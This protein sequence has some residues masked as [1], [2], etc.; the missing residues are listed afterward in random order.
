MMWMRLWELC[1]SVATALLQWP[2]YSGMY[3]VM[4]MGFLYTLVGGMPSVATAAAVGAV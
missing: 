2:C 3:K 1:K 4:E